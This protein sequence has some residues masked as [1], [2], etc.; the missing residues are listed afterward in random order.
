MVSGPTGH[1]GQGDV[2]LSAEKYVCDGWSPIPL[3]A[4]R[5]EPIKGIKIEKYVYTPEDFVGANVGVRL[6]SP[7]GGL[8]DVDADWDESRAIFPALLNHTGVD[9]AC[10]G[11]AT[12]PRSHHIFRVAD[13]P[14]A[15]KKFALPAS[16]GLRDL[17]SEHALTVIEFRC[18]GYTMFPPSVHPN[19]ECVAWD[20]DAPVVD[21]GLEALMRLVSLTAFLSV[22]RRYAPG[23]GSRQDFAGAFAGTM[24]RAGYD[25]D[26]ALAAYRLVV[27]GD[28]EMAARERFIRDTYVASAERKTGLPRLAEI[29]GLE[30]SVRDCLSRWLG[31]QASEVNAEIN[32]TYF[33]ATDGNRVRIYRYQH[34]PFAKRDKLVSLSLTDFE[35]E[36]NKWAALPNGQRVSLA[37]KWFAS[38]GRRYYK[39]GFVFDPSG[40]TYEDTLNLWRGFG[41]EARQGEWSL[42]RAHI[43]YVAGE[44]ADYVLKWLAWTVQNPDKLPESALVFRGGKGTGKGTV[45]KWMLRI[46]GHHSLHLT[47]SHLLTGRFNGH[48]RDCCL[49]FADESFWAGQKAEEGRLKALITEQSTVYEQKGRDAVAGANFVHLIIASNEDWVVPAGPD[50]RRYAVCD[51]PGKFAQDPRYFGPLYEQAE[52]GG[53]EAMLYDLRAMDLGNW[54]PRAVPKTKALRDQIEASEPPERALLR[55]ILQVGALPGTSE[56]TAV[57]A[58]TMPSVR[59]AVQRMPFGHKVKDKSIG[60]AMKAIAEDIDNNGRHFVGLRNDDP[61]R[62]EYKRCTQYIMPPLAEARRRFD[63]VADWDAGVTEWRAERIADDATGRPGKYDSGLDDTPF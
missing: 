60:T 23:E 14:K 57:N 6:G 51:V 48:Q 11:R 50:E 31:S 2:T 63:P 22:C 13:L 16:G 56:Y 41:V 20:N 62:P 5:K 8:V 27:T 1:A 39:N 10:F 35:L 28:E 3:V 29:M 42:L 34:D 54:H 9:T 17:P 43:Q 58:V 36:L 24:Q 18:S 26:D 61:N 21:I 40:A 12:A 49:A 46:F 15:S 37:R 4:G 30:N 32:E 47:D 7:S 44:L 52:N 53:I 59:E 45:A 55:R 25:L 19:G 33:G 38:P